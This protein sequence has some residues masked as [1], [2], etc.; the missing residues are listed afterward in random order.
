MNLTQA[1]Y[2][3]KQVNVF[4]NHPD[5]ALVGGQE[6][7]VDGKGNIIRGSKL[8]GI[9]YKKYNLFKIKQILFLISVL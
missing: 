8:D 7:L 9:I 5:V 1:G 3:K 2:N 6:D 4:K